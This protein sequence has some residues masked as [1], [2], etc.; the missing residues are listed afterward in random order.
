MK[1][2]LEEPY[3]SV[4]KAGYLSIGSD[5]RK[6]VQFTDEKGTTVSSTSYAR[7]LMSVK[8]GYFVP[9]GFEV[10]HRDN[11]FTNDDVANLQLL[12][13]EANRL[14]QQLHYVENIQNCYGFE[15]ADC[16]IRFL[17]PESKIKMR[18]AQGVKNAFCS[19]QCSVN[20]QRY[21]VGKPPQP[22]IEVGDQM[23]IKKLRSE[24]HSSYSISKITGF[25]RNTVM[26]YW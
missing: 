12:T 16:G 6:R 21:I 5:G 9:D 2:E 14:K 4:Y 22:V 25:A 20:Y 13:N 15:C 3:K 10:D 24:G 23:L 7:Y 8:L 17:L 26:K 11:D 1:I 19:H 18:Q